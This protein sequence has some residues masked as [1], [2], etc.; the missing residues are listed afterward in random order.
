M[1][2]YVPIGGGF[3]WY[4]IPYLDL[5]FDFFD[6]QPYLWKWSN[7]TS[8]LPRFYFQKPFNHSRFPWPDPDDLNLHV[9][10][11]VPSQCQGR[12]VRTKETTVSGFRQKTQT[13]WTKKSA[14]EFGYSPYPTKPPNSMFE[15]RVSLVCQCSTTKLVLHSEDLSLSSNNGYGPTISVGNHKPDWPWLWLWETLAIQKMLWEPCW[16]VVSIF[17]YFY[18]YLGKWFNLTIS[19]QSTSHIPWKKVPQ[20]QQKTS[21]QDLQFYT[22]RKIS[23]YLFG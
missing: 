13:D 16:V 6:F 7:L 23:T 5:W 17:F 8:Q 19:F 14:L 12:R 2:R 11:Q 18:S 9:K 4:F 21:T 22:H 10:S 1:I 3:K 20:A 15:F